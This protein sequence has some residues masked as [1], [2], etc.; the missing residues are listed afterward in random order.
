MI[1]GLLMVNESVVHGSGS[2]YVSCWPMRASYS[3]ILSD[4]LRGVDVKLGANR[5]DAIK[6]SYIFTLLDKPRE[7]M[8]KVSINDP[9]E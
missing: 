7:I 5:G 1:A 3:F 8:I 6:R 4:C 2:T 9:Y